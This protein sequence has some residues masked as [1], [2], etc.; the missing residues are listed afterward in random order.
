MVAAISAATDLL[1][2]LSLQ[3]AYGWL[4]IPANV[5]LGGGLTPSVLLL[6]K[7]PTWRWVSYGIVIGFGCAWFGLALGALFG[8]RA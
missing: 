5:L 1:L 8:V 7:M 6:R 4:W 3:V 2:T